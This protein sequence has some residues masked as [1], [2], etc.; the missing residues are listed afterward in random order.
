MTE[1]QRPSEADAGEEPEHVLEA[2]ALHAEAERLSAA[3]DDD[4]AIDKY[5]E[6][7]ARDPTR[8]AAWYDLGLVY[9]YRRAWPASLECYLRAFELDPGDEA[10]CWNLAIA[11]TALRDWTTARLAWRTTGIP[12]EGQAGPIEMD[13]GLTPVRLDPD[14]EAE[15]V[16]ARRIDPV[17]A[18]IESIPFPRS[19]FRHGD[20]VLHDGAAVGY[21]LDRHG[22]EKAVF[23]VFELFEAS[24]HVTF[25]LDLETTTEAD[26]TALEQICDDAGMIFEDWTANVRT[27][28]KACSE[29]R[30]H[31]EHDRDAPEA[32]QEWTPARRVA[33]AAMDARA[34][35]TIAMD[36]ASA[37]TGRRVAEIRGHPR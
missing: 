9:K 31:E 29:G 16:W 1:M 14:G 8:S 22:N 27:L 6:S 24:E 17:R 30:P 11:A 4:A 10:S 12:I 5:R 32:P 26:I 18:R 33:V 15:V 28:C 37:A 36:W 35:R 3:G 7:L 21:R 2:R 25:E 19:G 20:V 23:N 34:V 13:L